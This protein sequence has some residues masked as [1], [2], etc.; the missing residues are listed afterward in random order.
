MDHAKEADAKAIE[1]AVKQLKA[2]KASLERGLDAAL[3]QLD[4]KF[5]KGNT[6]QATIARWS[7]YIVDL[8]FKLD[9]SF[10]TEQMSVLQSL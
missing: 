8:H 1:E 4:R 10:S 9:S 6:W 3:A 5:K 2:K 7:H